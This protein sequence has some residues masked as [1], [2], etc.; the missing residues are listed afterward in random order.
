MVNWAR[1]LGPV[2]LA[3]GF[4]DRQVVDAG[5]AQAHQ[6][7]VVKLPVLVAVG[8]EPVAGIVSPFVGE[9]HGDAVIGEGPK[10]LD[11]AIV[12]LSGPLASKKGD[13]RLATDR[14]LG[15]VAPAAV[16]AIGQ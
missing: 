14:E 7:L 1:T 8:A 15:T 16:L 5:I 10:L 3:V 12:E 4:S 9:A 2:I 13:D 6:A 11:Q